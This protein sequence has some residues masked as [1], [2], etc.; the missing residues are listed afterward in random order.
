MNIANILKYCPKGTKLYSTVYGDVVLDSIYLKN[1]KF[2]IMIKDCKGC[3]HLLT[4]QGHYMYDV[5][6]SE[7]VLFPSKEQRDWNKFRLPVK[8]GDIMMEIDGSYPF[9]ASGEF[10]KNGFPKYICGINLEN[11]LQMDMGAGWTSEFCIPASEE[12]KK[13][14]FDK[15]AEASYKWNSKTLKLEKVKQNKLKPF[16][17]VLVRDNLNEKWSV[18]LFSYYCEEDEDFPYACINGYYDQCIP[19]EGNEYLLGTNNNPQ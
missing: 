3:E 9:I 1:G 8:R 4:E 7:C 16:D 11:N 13:K 12:V 19:Y 18:S 6:N 2:P 17:K 15:I 10:T 5:P 14:L